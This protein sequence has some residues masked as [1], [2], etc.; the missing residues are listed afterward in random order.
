M[1]SEQ[2]R[3][4]KSELRYVG[5]RRLI[6]QEQIKIRSDELE[7]LEHEA[8]RL[9]QVYYTTGD[10]K[11]YTMFGRIDQLYR[12]IQQLVMDELSLNFR[13]QVIEDKI[14]CLWA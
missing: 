2:K 14:S 12:E 4:L 13:I 3:E 8:S 7:R 10:Q 6:V 11:V 1:T 5:R 9:I